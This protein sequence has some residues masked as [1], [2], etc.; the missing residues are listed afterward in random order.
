MEDDLFGVQNPETSEFGF[1]SIMGT[2]GEHLAISVYLGPEG[3]YG[4]WDL[5][6]A[7]PMG[8][9][10]QI[11]EIPQ[12]QASFEDRKE[13][14][15]RDRDLIKQLSLKFRGQRA[16]PM[17]RSF[18]PGF[19]PWFLEAAEVRFL[20]HVLEQ[21]AD[22]AERSLANPDLLEPPDEDTY[23]MRIPQPT[24]DGLVWSDQL[25]AVPSPQPASIS[26]RM[27]RQALAALKSAPRGRQTL[28]ADFFLL[29]MATQQE[30]G[31]R[32]YY[33]YVLM[34][35]EQQSGMILGS[36]ILKPEP[37]L[38]DMWGLIPLNLVQQLYRLG[39]VP[40]EIKI[41]SPLLLQLLQPLAKDL[42]FKLKEVKK[43]PTLDSA[44]EFMFQ[45][46]W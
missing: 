13:L 4:F 41:R 27:D 5:E 18:R 35:V 22:V 30:R 21:T 39:M 7:G 11:L 29:P 8:S 20:T 14:Q 2:L 6:D 19:V 45:S 42:G 36:E 23:L 33:P 26:V 46:F 31:V 17:F 43:L 16:W 25:M 24:G 15:Q 34:M 44:K 12:L 28:E 1:V 38:T 3:L 9:A 40:K 37:T 32:P 10:E